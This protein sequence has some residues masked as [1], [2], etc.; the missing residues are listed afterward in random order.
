M[1]EVCKTGGKSSVLV[2]FEETSSYERD[3][4]TSASLTMNISASPSF[5]S[6]IRQH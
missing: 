2:A 5:G 4:D 3:L 6:A 1:I